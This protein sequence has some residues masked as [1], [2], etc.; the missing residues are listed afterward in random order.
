MQIKLLSF[1][2]FYTYQTNSEACFPFWGGGSFLFNLRFSL[3]ESHYEKIFSRVYWSPLSVSMKLSDGSCDL[4]YT[5]SINT[6]Q[7]F[8]SHQ[9]F[10]SLCTTVTSVFETTA[11]LKSDGSLPRLLPWLIHWKRKWRRKSTSGFLHEEYSPSPRFYSH[12][13]TTFK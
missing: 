8:G 7:T 4:K 11:S 2:L 12:L 3:R 1:S 5:E 10:L 13:S 6:L 9:T